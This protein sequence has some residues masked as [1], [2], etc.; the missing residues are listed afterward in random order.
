MPHKDRSEQKIG[1][2]GVG[3]VG[4]AVE[5]WFKEKRNQPVYIYDKF[6]NLGSV[7]EV[8]EA[9]YI[10]ICVPTPFQNGGYDDSAVIESLKNLNGKG[11]TVI[12]KSTIIPGSTQR[13]Q[14][15]F[16]QHRILFN[17]EFLVARTAN[18][19]FVE[20]DRQ[21]IGFTEQSE[22]V[23][24]EVLLL[25]PNAPFQ[26]IV[27]ATEAELIKYFG[28]TF[29][30]TRVIFAN[31]MYDLCQKLGADYELILECA[32]EDKRIGKSHFDIFHDGGRGYAGACLPKDTRA[33]IELGDKVGTP[34]EL[35]KAVERIND[36][37]VKKYPKKS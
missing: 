18:K 7:E 9:D 4:G 24:K 35:L 29:L 37:L 16:P 19:D 31:Q 10:F 36:E 17:P 22:S 30:S 11:K 6:K 5:H 3:Y 15:E 20:P 21:I 8:N 27:P 14:K 33:L 25:L 26:R 1:I 28:N 34:L 32:G 13:Y 12:I 2:I 23:A